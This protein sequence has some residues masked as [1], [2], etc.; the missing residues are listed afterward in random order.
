MASFYGRLLLL[1]GLSDAN[2]AFAIHEAAMYHD[3][4]R[5]V[6]LKV[7]SRDDMAMSADKYLE[8]IRVA[9][10]TANAANGFALSGDE[11][12][13]MIVISMLN[14]QADEYI[15]SVVARL[16]EPD[17]QVLDMISTE[18]RRSGPGPPAHS[19]SGPATLKLTVPGLSQSD[20]RSPPKSPAF[21]MLPKYYPYSAPAALTA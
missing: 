21:V 1:Q 3:R 5:R 20:C 14:Y 19:S 7:F 15:E 9:W 17:S 10:T 16:A 6:R 13:E 11:I 8:Y 18:I 4:L 12:W 2:M